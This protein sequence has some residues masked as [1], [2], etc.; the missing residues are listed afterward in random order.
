M[1]DSFVYSLLLCVGKAFCQDGL[2]SLS[3]VSNLLV[4]FV[5][6]CVF[7]MIMFFLLLKKILIYKKMLDREELEKEVFR[8]LHHSSMATLAGAS[9]KPARSTGSPLWGQGHLLLLSQHTSREL[10]PRWSSLNPSTHSQGMPALQEAVSLTELPSQP[11]GSL[12]LTSTPLRTSYREGLV[13]MHSSSFGGCERY[14]IVLCFK[15]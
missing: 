8:L 2:D 13:A 3:F 6:Q 11:Q 10:N 4:N 15:G 14:F 7:M 5:L 12:L 1:V 9:P